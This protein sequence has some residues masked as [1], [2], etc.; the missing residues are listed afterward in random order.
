MPGQ[1]PPGMRLAP[2][3]CGID[4]PTIGV[5][6][7]QSSRTYARLAKRQVRSASKYASIDG[8]R[9]TRRPASCK[10]SSGQALDMRDSFVE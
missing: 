9:S 6:A 10:A 7:T 1:R 4:M 2:R 3:I 8:T 5:A